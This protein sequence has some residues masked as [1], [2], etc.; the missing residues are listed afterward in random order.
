VLKDRNGASAGKA[1]YDR[2]REGIM[3]GRP[4]GGRVRVASAKA[5]TKFPEEIHAALER[6]V[7]KG[8]MEAGASG[9]PLVQCARKFGKTSPMVGRPSCRTQPSLQAGIIS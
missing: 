6:T 3:E 9:G 7:N 8:E 4:L 5:G 2:H 1:R